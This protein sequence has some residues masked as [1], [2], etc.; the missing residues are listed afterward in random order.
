MHGVAGYY[1]PL[2]ETL[3]TV[4]SSTLASINA[5]SWDSGHR[6]L[7][8]P[9]FDAFRPHLKRNGLVHRFHETNLLRGDS[10]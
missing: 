8:L 6:G 4:R 1:E 10:I 7:D 9:Y 3:A 5:E 2:N